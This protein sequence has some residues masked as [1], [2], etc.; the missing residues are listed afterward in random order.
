MKNI[1]TFCL[2]M[3]AVLNA[4]AQNIN[5][6]GTWNEVDVKEVHHVEG[7]IVQNT[8]RIWIFNA[9][10]TKGSKGRQTLTY[11]IGGINCKFDI[12]QTRTEEKWVLQDNTISLTAIPLQLTLDIDYL[13]YGN[14][15]AAQKQ[16]IN[17]ALPAFKKQ[18]I[19]EARTE[20]QQ[21]M[22]GRRYSYT[23]TSYNPKQMTLSDG[24]QR[25]TLVRDLT[26]MTPAQKTAFD[27][28]W[29]AYETAK[30]ETEEK[31]RR[32]VEE[33][34][35]AYWAKV[36]T[37]KKTSAAKAAEEGVAL[38]D[39]GLSVRWASRNIG[40]TGMNERG[41]RYAWGEVVPRSNGKNYNPLIKLVPGAVLDAT[42]DPATVAWGPGW[43]VPTVQQWNELFAKCSFKDNEDH[44]GIIVTGPS[45]NSIELPHTGNRYMLQYWANSCDRKKYANFAMILLNEGNGTLDKSNTPKIDDLPGEVYI[46]VRA[47]ME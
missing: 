26:K 46:P 47:V 22:M 43:H 42:C 39:L 45:G 38:V 44:T 40:G 16:K 6:I 17:A 37:E 4:V 12:M 25:Y 11:P 5:L 8:K 24:R 14:F 30:R 31:A 10:G 2:A 32:E 28:E 34:E 7:V 13:K 1:V 3:T 9:D 36:G 41:Y 19:S 29:T 15:T 21:T 23:I 33:R 35:N 20:W 27:K 18:A